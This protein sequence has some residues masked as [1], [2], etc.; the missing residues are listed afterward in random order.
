MKKFNFLNVSRA[1][2]A[3]ALLIVFTSCSDD[4]GGSTIEDPIASFQFAVSSEN[5]LEVSFTNFSQNATAYAWDF[6]DQAGVSTDAEPT[7]TYSAAGT[8]TVT[9][10]AA[11]EAGATSTFS[12]EVSITD[13]NSALALLAG[14][15]SKTWKLFREGTSMSLGPNADDPAA[16]WPGLT[17][18]GSR[19]CLYRQ[20]FTFTRDGSYIFDDMGEFWAEFGVFN[21]VEGC[22]SN[23]RAESCFEATAANMVN[24]CGDDVSAWLS[25]TH[26]Y[27]YEPTAN[28]ITLSGEGAWMGIPKL[29]NDG[30]GNIVPVSEVTFKATIIQETGYDVLKLEFDYGDAGYWPV[31]YVNYSDASLE[32]E[33]VTEATEFGEDLD[34]ITPTSM[35]HTFESETSFEHLGTIAG[36]STIEVGADDPTDASA[37]KVGQFNRTDAQFQ[38]AQF[39]GNPDPKDITFTNLTTISLEV[40]LPSTNDYTG[41]LTKKVVVGFADQSATEQWWTD[42]YQY[43]SAELATDEWVTVSFQ[44]DAPSFVSAGD[45]STPFDREDLDMFYVQIGGGDHTTT[46]TFYVRNLIID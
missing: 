40:Y 4:D 28:T 32:P 44:I 12:E 3:F 31:Y 17:N 14:T 37:A 6:G 8:Y 46:G 26:S 16:W 19:P 27:S 7:Y 10:V 42:L 20:T 38:E 25:G 15:D 23:V 43:E 9:L 18:D 21:N 24:A 29:G 30:A 41:S 35:S 36:A 33:L 22:D 13:P 2:M 1:V 11:N 34:N 5:F 39:T 45:G